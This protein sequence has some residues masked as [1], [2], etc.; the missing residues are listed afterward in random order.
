MKGMLCFFVVVK[1]T[2][3]RLLEDATPRQT[4]TADF[5]FAPFDRAQWT[6]SAQG[7]ESVKIR[8]LHD[9]ARPLI[10]KKVNQKLFELG[11]E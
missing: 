10:T 7:K 1:F 5:F 6:L 9:N 3:C 4:F 2:R 11:W 8:F